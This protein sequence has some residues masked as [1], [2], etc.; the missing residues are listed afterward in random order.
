MEVENYN[1]AK[2]SVSQNGIINIVAR[3]SVVHKALQN[4]VFSDLLP[5]L[6]LGMIAD[7]T[8]DRETFVEDLFSLNANQE[9]RSSLRMQKRLKIQRVKYSCGINY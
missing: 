6:F 4:K 2:S 3:W 5:V 7:G 9:I 1:E 8:L